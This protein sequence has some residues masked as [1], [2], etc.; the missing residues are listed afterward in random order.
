MMHRIRVVSVK[1]ISTT[2]KSLLLF[3]A[4]GSFVLFGLY[5]FVR[6][7]PCRAFSEVDLI[8]DLIWMDAWAVAFFAVVVIIWASRVALRW[9]VALLLGMLAVYGVVEIALMYAG[10]PFGLNAYWGDQQFRQAMI[11]KFITFAVPG[12]YYYRDLPLFYPP[13]YYFLLSLYARLFSVEAYK[14][15]K[16]GTMAIYLIGPWLLYFFWRKLVAPLQAFMVT[17]VSFLVCS[18]GNPF[19]QSAPHAFLTNTFF[20]PWWLFFIERVGNPRVTWKYL[21]AGGIIGAA[22]FVT[23]FYPFFILAFLLLLRAT[24]LRGYDFFRRID[25]FRW[26][27]AVGV[28]VIAA[29]LSAPYWLPV[30]VSMVQHGLDRSRGGWHHMGSTGIMVEYMQFSLVGLLFLGGIAVAVT[31]RAVH[32]YRPLIVFL[33]VIVLYLLAGSVLGAL[34]LPINLIKAR[35]FVSA[36]A[37]VFI[38]LA[39]ADLLRWSRFRPRSRAAV[40][41][42]LAVVLLIFLHNI[43]LV[44]KSPMV[45]VARSAAVPTWE[46]D[47]AEM[48]DRAGTVFLTGHSEL[49]SFYPVYTFLAA[50]EHYSHPAS[51]F[52][53]RFDFLELLQGERDPY[54]F[55]LALQHNVFDRVDYF[56]P[57]ATDSSFQIQINLSNYPNALATTFLEYDTSVVS[58]CRLFVPRKGRKL[59]Q[60]VDPI[61]IAC[62]PPADSLSLRENLL[63]AARRSE[64]R[65]GLDSAG[66][67]ALDEYTG[68]H[69][70]PLSDIDGTSGSHR[71]GRQV[72]LGSCYYAQGPDSTYLL[73]GFRAMTNLE[74]KY[75]VYLH[76]FRDGERSTHDFWP[77]PATTTWKSGDQVWLIKALPRLEHPFS[78][79]LGLYDGDRHLGEGFTGR[80]V[81]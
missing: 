25:R 22:L 44:A 38:G 78:F 76:V 60:V 23:Y 53:Q 21:L 69:L 52:K 13:L 39:A 51:R 74:R 65:K 36:F 16:L 11:L 68:K 30:L 18:F 64:I 14:M 48:A 2:K 41:V 59:F 15:L 43:N 72:E 12:D 50:N 81:R 1:S 58:D 66:C 54:V 45:R 42:V 26:K 80:S 17:L 34:D 49:C 46:T 5:L 63:L 7:F 32:L 40:P 75:R 56:M 61:A 29:V 33:G 19:V 71:F 8:Y 31:R 37:G 20:I 6:S 79:T 24:L 73:L 77:D 67:R 27:P 47:A 10:T 55:A 57:R 3:G 70:L 62:D 35:N 9:K 28:L 4:L